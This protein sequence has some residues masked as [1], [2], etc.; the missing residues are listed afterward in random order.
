MKDAAS[1]LRDAAARE[2]VTRTY[3]RDLDAYWRWISRAIGVG[4]LV[5]VGVWMGILAFAGV[6]NLLHYRLGLSPA[7]TFGALGILAL[8]VT[9]V[10]FSARRVP[11]FLV[12][13]VEA[14][15]LA[16]APLTLWQITRLTLT[17]QVVIGTLATTLG[18]VLLAFLTTEAE[19]IALALRLL[20]VALSVFALWLHRHA[21]HRLHLERRR[22][23]FQAVLLPALFVADLVGLAFAGA[24]PLL[25]ALTAAMLSTYITQTGSATWRWL[26]SGTLSEGLAQKLHLKAALASGRFAGLMTGQSPGRANVALQR[27]LN[28]TKN[29]SHSSAGLLR[30]LE[31]SDVFVARSVIELRRQGPGAW[32]SIALNVVFFTVACAVQTAA[33]D[34]VGHVL[35]IVVVSALL[36]RLYAGQAL[37][38]HFPV[39]PERQFFGELLPRALALA[40]CYLLCAALGFV[41]SSN[42]IVGLPLAALVHSTSF[43]TLYRVRRLLGVSEYAREGQLVAANLALLPLMLAKLFG[44]YDMVGWFYLAFVVLVSVNVVPFT[45]SA[46][47]LVQR[48]IRP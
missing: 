45:R 25:G 36:A 38:A 10:N 14:D 12:S 7:Q 32:L 16:R 17:A 34:P 47:V 20:N 21:L 18:I 39:R 13:R 4:V 30:V 42:F 41:F 22:Y 29:L 19:P 3:R 23:T 46:L 26:H 48:L 27:A 1:R 35:L 5:Y 8:A 31:R 15:G 43:Y 40:A 24:V 33:F 9:V 37:P 2:L 6:Q 28:E 44:V 11:P